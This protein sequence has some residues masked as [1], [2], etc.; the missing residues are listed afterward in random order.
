MMVNKTKV[1]TLHSSPYSEQVENCRSD[2]ASV[3]CLCTIQ[4]DILSLYKADGFVKLLILG[5]VTAQKRKQPALA[6]PS[7]GQDNRSA[8]QYRMTWMVPWFSDE[9]LF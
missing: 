5:C 4:K 8:V 2:T 6:N 9:K 1:Y 7:Q 3:H